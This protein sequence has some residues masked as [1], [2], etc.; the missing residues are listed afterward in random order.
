MKDVILWVSVALVM[1]GFGTRLVVSKETRACKAAVAGC[2]VTTY[3]VT[4]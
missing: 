3:T 4:P 1:M 2:T